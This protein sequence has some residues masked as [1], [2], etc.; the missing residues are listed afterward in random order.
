MVRK[1]ER[2]LWLC[3]KIIT[4][5]ILPTLS[6]Q[7]Y[8]YTLNWMTRLLQ[9]KDP[10][11]IE[12]LIEVHVRG[13]TQSLT[14]C[15]NFL[16]I[17]WCFDFSSLSVVNPPVHFSLRHLACIIC[18]YQTCVHKNMMNICRR[19]SLHSTHFFSV[20]SVF[21]SWFTVGPLFIS[22]FTK[23]RGMFPTIIFCALSR[24]SYL[25]WL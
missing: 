22:V 11:K 17:Y 12:T 1:L 21:N 18:F 7:V 5:Y 6:V 20:W 3:H 16:N 13:K 4:F 19:S 9:C 14:Q 2:N 15:F 23:V 8:K 10:L 25:I 24:F